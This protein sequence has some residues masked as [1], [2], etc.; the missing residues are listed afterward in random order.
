VFRL[1]SLIDFGENS[2]GGIDEAD[3]SGVSQF[4]A[5]SPAFGQARE[6]GSAGACPVSA[7]AANRILPGS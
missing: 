4:N 2:L 1:N 7:F 6:S 5:C 3:Y